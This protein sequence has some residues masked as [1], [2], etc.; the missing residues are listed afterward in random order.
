MLLVIL[1]L[2]VV[3]PLR[4]GLTNPKYFNLHLLHTVL[5]LKHSLLLDSFSAR[6]FQRDFDKLLLFFHD[7]WYTVDV[8]SL[9][10]LC[11]LNRLFELNNVD[12]I[13]L[14]ILV[15][16]IEHYL[17]TPVPYGNSRN[18]KWN[19][20]SNLQSYEK[21]GTKKDK[22]ILLLHAQSTTK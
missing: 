22:V 14:Y 2:A 6:K 21:N 16:E 11:I 5:T 10:P 17:Y 7:G 3:I 4:F 9:A 12:L 13:W 19:R 15:A 18:L 1:I 8:R 20:Q